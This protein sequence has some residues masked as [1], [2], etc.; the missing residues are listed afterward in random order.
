MIF[1]F[2]A[3]SLVGAEEWVGGVKG[4]WAVHGF[5]DLTEPYGFA[6]EQEAKGVAERARKAN[7]TYSSAG[8][9][10]SEQNHSSQKMYVRVC[11]H[12]L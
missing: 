10:S 5:T 2:V 4:K 11:S 12:Q 9:L 3:L 8:N 1:L 6:E 7:H